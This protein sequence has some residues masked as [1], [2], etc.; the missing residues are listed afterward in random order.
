MTTYDKKPWIKFYDK[1][2]PPEAPIQ[3]ITYQDYLETGINHDPDAAAYHFLGAFTA[4][5]TYL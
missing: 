5:L 3:D 4:T 1:D 2:V